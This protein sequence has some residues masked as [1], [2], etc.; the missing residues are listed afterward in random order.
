M[1]K[2]DPQLIKLLTCVA[3]AGIVVISAFLP[4]GQDIAAEALRVLA[5]GMV[6]GVMVR[7]P[8]DVAVTTNVDD[9]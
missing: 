4:E 5:A 7:R 9:L 8:G 3:S 2:L 6:T 1:P